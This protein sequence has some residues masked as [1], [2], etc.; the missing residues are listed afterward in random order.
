MAEHNCT[1]DLIAPFVPM[2]ARWLALSVQAGPERR[3]SGPAACFRMK[4]QLLREHCRKSQ[5]WRRGSV[6]STCGKE[7]ECYEVASERLNI[8]GLLCPADFRRQLKIATAVADASR[9]G[10]NQMKS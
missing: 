2:I 4:T 9:V 10:E 7:T 6:A 3:S 5:N 1:P 8:H